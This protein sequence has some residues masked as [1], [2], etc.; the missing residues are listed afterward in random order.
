[1]PSAG[2]GFVVRPDALAAGAG[3]VESAVNQVGQ[4]AGSLVGVGGQLADAVGQPVAADAA[5]EL[6][7][8]WVTQL[9]R[10]E[11]LVDGLGMAVG[12]ASEL[13]ARGDEAVAGALERGSGP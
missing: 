12:L 4:L 6:T 3:A 11:A 8:R 13:Y 2:D 7:L 9:R 10:L 5:L 1:M